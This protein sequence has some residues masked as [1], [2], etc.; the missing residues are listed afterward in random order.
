MKEYK[1]FYLINGE[2]LNGVFEIEEMVYDEEGY[3][4]AMIEKALL[5]SIDL[6]NSVWS[7]SYHRIKRLHMEHTYEILIND[8]DYTQEAAMEETEYSVLS[9]YIE[10]ATHSFTSYVENIERA[11][12]KDNLEDF[13]RCSKT[14]LINDK[15]FKIVAGNP[16]SSI[17]DVKLLARLNN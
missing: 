8:Y 4:Y 5:E 9:D 1:L 6:N 11:A 12:Q 17:S 16:D 7:N 13:D 2:P 10:G 14:Q 15:T 3:F